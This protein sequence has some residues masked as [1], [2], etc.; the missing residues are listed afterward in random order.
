MY[1]YV[2]NNVVAF[3]DRLGLYPNPHPAPHPTP[4]PCS[5]TPAGY[6]F[7]EDDH[8]I[9]NFIGILGSFSPTFTCACKC[10]DCHGQI[11]SHTA[12]SRNLTDPQQELE[13]AEDA[14]N[15]LLGELSGAEGTQKLLLQTQLA[16]A[17]TQVKADD[18]AEKKYKSGI[19]ELRQKCASDCSK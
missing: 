4:T 19:E 9:L 10:K 15:D 12:W 7:T 3:T 8:P 18:V 11:Q 13:D 2:Q 5:C 17:E 6:D 1:D 16:T 14:V